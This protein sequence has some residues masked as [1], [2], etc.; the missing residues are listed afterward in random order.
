MNIGARPWANRSKGDAIRPL[1][2]DAHGLRDMYAA[3]TTRN[4]VALLNTWND[5]DDT[6]S[7]AATQKVLCQPSS[8]TF[9]AGP[10]ADYCG[11]VSATGPGRPTI[12][13]STAICTGSTAAVEVALKAR[14]MRRCVPARTNGNVPLSH[15]STT[16]C[17]EQ[18]ARKTMSACHSRN[19]RCGRSGSRSGTAITCPLQ[20]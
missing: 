1:P 12:F 17:R 2:D 3:L 7:G 4:E 5:A 6:L 11:T 8:G 10:F 13:G 15:R 19:S 18:A 14:R 9:S 16:C 20:E